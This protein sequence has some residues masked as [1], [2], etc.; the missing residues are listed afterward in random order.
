MCKSL[1]SLLS[2]TVVLVTSCCTSM[3]FPVQCHKQ[4]PKLSSVSAPDINSL[5]LVIFIMTDNLD[6]QI[7][8]E[9]M[10]T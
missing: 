1:R 9:V 2:H 7:R 4:I 5:L 8:S 3:L 6:P 10:L